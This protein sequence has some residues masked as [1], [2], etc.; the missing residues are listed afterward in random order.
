MWVAFANAKATHI[1]SSKTVSIYA[2]FNDQSFNDPLTNGIV[3]FEQLGPGV[4][5]KSSNLLCL[6]LHASVSRTSSVIKNKRVF[7]MII[8]CLQ[9]IPISCTWVLHLPNICTIYLAVSGDHTALKYVWAVSWENVPLK[10]ICCV[11]MYLRCMRA[12]WNHWGMPG[13]IV[14]IACLGFCVRIRRM[15]SVIFDS[16]YS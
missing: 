13:A 9:N 12:I 7:P 8:V 11:K 14:Y 10:H 4:L 3:S 16:A 15:N 5:F 6:S 1:F 2:I